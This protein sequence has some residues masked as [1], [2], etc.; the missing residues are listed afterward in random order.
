MQQLAVEIIASCNLIKF[1]YYSQLYFKQPII[2]NKILFIT[3]DCYF[4][5]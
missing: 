4:I 3:A 5:I 1:E 2:A